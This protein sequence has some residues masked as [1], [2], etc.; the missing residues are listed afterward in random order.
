MN[1]LDA[2]PRRARC[3]GFVARRRMLGGLAAL[4]APL[5]SAAL[6]LAAATDV[7]AQAVYPERPIRIVVPY[8]PGGTSDLFARLIAQQL[9][10][11]WG[12]QAIVENRAGGGTVIGATAVARA[13]PDGYTLLFMNNTHVINPLLMANLPY[14]AFKDFTPITTLASSPYLLLTKAAL[15]ARTLAD[16]IA[17]AKKRPGELNYGTGG[18]GGLTHLAGELFN[19][20]AGTKIAMVHYKGAAPLTNA[21]LAGEIDAYL[22]VPATTVPHIRA[23]KLNVIAVTG[24]ARVAALPD[25]PTT[26]EAG[27]PAF[28]VTITY[29]L[30]GPAGL[31]PAVVAKLAGELDRIFSRA[32]IKDKLEGMGLTPVRSSPD[33][34]ARWLRSEQS[35][36]DRV[37]KDAGIK[38]E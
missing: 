30:L 20:A 33:G 29:G 12:Q 3:S 27:L 32:G 13:A 23:G 2:Q 19:A 5:L 25:V 38:A 8:A 18:P 21:A 34:F 22:D 7:G 31:P 11:A 35:R 1:R 16:Y 28:E 37:I 26:A 10:E 15:P 4:L 6:S 36:F 9:S 17:L 14:D 24:P